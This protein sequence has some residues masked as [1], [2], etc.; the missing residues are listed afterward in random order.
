MSADKR[1]TRKTRPFDARQFMAEAPPRTGNP[2][3]AAYLVLDVV[4]EEADRC[5]HSGRRSAAAG[6]I[7]G[8]LALN[9]GP[10]GSPHA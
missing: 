4:G 1:E 2:R 7:L 5:R 8:T 6:W 10:H 9:A 3:P